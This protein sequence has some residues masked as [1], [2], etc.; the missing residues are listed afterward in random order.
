M[1]LRRHSGVSW[2][3]AACVGLLLGAC[4][5]GGGG[6]GDG[7]SEGT[8]TE[9]TLA[10]LAGTWAGAMVDSYLC[11]GAIGTIEITISGGTLT[12]TGGDGSSFSVDDTGTISQSDGQSFATVMALSGDTPGRFLVD[13]AAGHAVWAS[14]SSSGSGI[15]YVGLLQKGSLQST[16]FSATDIVGAWSGVAVRLDGNL[17]VTASSDSTASITYPSGLALS[18]TDGDGAFSA[19]DPGLQLYDPSLGIWTT[20]TDDSSNPVTW[21]GQATAAIYVMSSDKTRVAVGFLD[22]DDDR[23][24]NY[25]AFSTDM[26]DNKFVLWEQQ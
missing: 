2:A 22:D 18:G 5:S 9:V 23:L 19:G 4:A 7:S 25:D 26:A 14:P 3:V 10:A 6:S 17:D 12:V 16:T 20:D 8:T 1:N 21:S 13:A 15:G 24:C 11:E